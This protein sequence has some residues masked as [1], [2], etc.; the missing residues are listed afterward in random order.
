VTETRAE[1]RRVLRIRVREEYRGSDGRTG[2]A[3]ARCGD[4]SGQ[5]YRPVEDERN[6]ERET[7]GGAPYT[8]GSGAAA[9]E[10]VWETGPG[11]YRKPLGWD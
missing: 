10:T 3:S 9:R 8:A 5:D 6:G 11:R 1:E 4:C 7:P 2:P